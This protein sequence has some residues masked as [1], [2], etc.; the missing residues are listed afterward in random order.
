MS[1]HDLDWRVEPGVKLDLAAIAPVGAPLALRPKARGL[2]R[3]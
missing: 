2:K 3:N 1:L